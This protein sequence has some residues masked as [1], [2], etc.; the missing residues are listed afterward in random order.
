M[1][2]DAYE[3]GLIMVSA[4][5]TCLRLAPALIIPDEDIERGL[6]ILTEVL[7]G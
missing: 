6:E 3:K 4:G 5:T 7:G 1:L 2:N